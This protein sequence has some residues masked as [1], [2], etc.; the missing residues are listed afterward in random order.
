MSAF[1]DEVHA[2]YGDPKAF[3]KKLRQSMVLH[4]ITQGAVASR[5]GFQPS[6]LSRWLNMRVTPDMATMVILDET[7]ETLIKKP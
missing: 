5:S 7:L 2:R 6:D 3:T 1:F 4:G